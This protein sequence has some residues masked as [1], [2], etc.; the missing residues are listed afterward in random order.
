MGSGVKSS[1]KGGF[2]E[3][4]PKTCPQSTLLHQALGVQATPAAA[5]SFQS[6]KVELAILIFR[7]F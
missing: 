7:L 5:F 6:C 4:Q 1:G 2:H 3:G